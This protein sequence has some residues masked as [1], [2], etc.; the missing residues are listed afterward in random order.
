MISPEDFAEL[1]ADLARL[2]D[3]D[4]RTASALLAQI[5][6]TPELSEDGR[7]VIVWKGT[8]YQ[9]TWPDDDLED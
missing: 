9:L 4:L 2:N 6:D 1:A 8:E 3:L 5:G 7:V